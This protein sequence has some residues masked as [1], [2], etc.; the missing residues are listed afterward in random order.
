MVKNLR[1]EIQRRNEAEESGKSPKCHMCGVEECYELSVQDGQIIK[2]YLQSVDGFLCIDC[3]EFMVNSGK[4]YTKLQFVM[5]MVIIFFRR[6]SQN[7]RPKT[8]GVK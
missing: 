8:G 5:L 3:Y 7:P 6:I 4:W 2:N 1:K